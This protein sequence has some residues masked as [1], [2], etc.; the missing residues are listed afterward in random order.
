MIAVAVKSPV[1]VRRQLLLVAAHGSSFDALA[2]DR[3]ADHAVDIRRL[4]PHDSV[5]TGFARG[6]PLVAD[7]V[8]TLVGTD[9]GTPATLT[10]VPFMT[11]AG[12][13]QPTHVPPA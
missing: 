9:I 1:A 6:G 5:E 4:V 12:L 11:S 13:K 10:V 3:I 7:A 2:R 8:R